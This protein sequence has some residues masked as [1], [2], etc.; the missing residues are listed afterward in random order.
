M[1][2]TK[3]VDTQEPKITREEILFL[4]DENFNTKNVCLVTG[5]GTGIGRATAV[6][7]AANN[8]MT[9]GLDINAEEGDKTCKMVDEIGGKMVF[10][11]TDLTQDEDI[12]NAIGEAAKLGTIKFLLNYSTRPIQVFGFLGMGSG[13]IGFLICLYLSIGRLFIRTEAFSLK[14]RMPL[15][16]LGILMILIGVQLITMGLLGEIM[17]RTYHESQRKPIYVI[18]EIV[19]DKK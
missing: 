4:Q 18:K 6:A 19:G 5:A 10:I 13:V 7:A 8:L 14:E 1:V 2:T 11:Q 9:V 17:I 15:L 3:P 16:L 12:E